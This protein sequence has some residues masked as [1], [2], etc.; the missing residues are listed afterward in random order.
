MNKTLISNRAKARE[1]WGEDVPPWILVLAAQCDERSQKA[2]A[3]K[4]GISGG[5]ISR[6]I[7][8]KYNG[9]YSEAALAVRSHLSGETVSCPAIGEIPLS[10]CIRGRRH[11]G[12]AQTFLQRVYASSCPICPLN[13]E[14][15]TRLEETD[16]AA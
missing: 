10:S 4:I 1:A 7:N 12:P 8:G 14:R 2:V 6:I 11:T 3:D 15:N 13:P 9:N 5:Q 16:N